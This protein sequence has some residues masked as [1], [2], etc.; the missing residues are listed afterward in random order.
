MPKTLTV[1]D[2]AKALAE[3]LKAEKGK[4]ELV[5]NTRK[6]AIAEAKAARKQAKADCREAIAKAKTGYK[7]AEAEIRKSMDEARTAAGDVINLTGYRAWKIWL[8][9]GSIG[10]CTGIVVGLLLRYVWGGAE[11]HVWVPY[12]AGLA[13]GI[14]GGGLSFLSYYIYRK[15]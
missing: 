5:R 8:I 9:V 4:F 7:T 11:E 14:V 13:C 2:A 6:T 1:K 10:I 3:A 15:R 12:V